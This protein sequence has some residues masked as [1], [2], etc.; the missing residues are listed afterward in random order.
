MWCYLCAVEPFRGLGAGEVSRAPVRDGQLELDVGPKHVVLRL[1]DRVVTI[2]DQFIR[3]GNESRRL[4][5]GIWLARNVPHDDLGIWEEQEHHR[6][7]RIFGAVPKP[8]DADGGL[9]ALRALDY[10]A[11][12]LRAALAVYAGNIPPRAIEVGRSGDEA[13]LLDFG[14]RLVLYTRPLFRDG[15]RR[16]LVAHRDG[17]VDIFDGDRTVKITVRSRFGV[18][19][20]GDQL[21]F[22]DPSG[23][24]LAHISAPWISRE[25]RDELARRIGDMIHVSLPGELA[26]QRANELPSPLAL[27]PS[28]KKPFRRRPRLRW[29]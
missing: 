7:R 3:I 1:A 16:A 22:A 24:D 12:R 20:L 14:D 19:V 10:V 9:D 17:R 18:T 25:D 27:R 15:A 28:G 4:A 23:L 6:V 8:F 5:G 29:R 13:L 26:A 11:T 2:T 21:R